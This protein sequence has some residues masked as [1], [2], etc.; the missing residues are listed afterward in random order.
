MFVVFEIFRTSVNGIHTV[1]VSPKTYH[2]AS[3]ALCPKNTPSAK[4]KRRY[5]SDLRGNS[6][7]RNDSLNTLSD[8]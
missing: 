4:S 2:F 5:S 6:A 1:D 3:G 8:L 7:E